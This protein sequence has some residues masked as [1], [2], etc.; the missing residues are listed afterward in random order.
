LY[1]SSDVEG[2]RDEVFPRRGVDEDRTTLLGR[3]TLEIVDRGCR[4][5]DEDFFDC[6]GL[7]MTSEWRLGEPGKQGR[8]FL[9]I[10]SAV[11]GDFQVP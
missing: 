1:A 4:V 2:G 11:I 3:S 9:V 8:T 7:E 10:A 6:V 5:I